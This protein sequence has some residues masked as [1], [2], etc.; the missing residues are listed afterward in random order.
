MQD[1]RERWGWPVP[2]AQSDPLDQVAFQVLGGPMG[3]RAPLAWLG[4]PVLWGLVVLW[5]LQAR[6]VWLARWV[7]V[8]LLPIRLLQT[9]WACV[10]Q[11]WSKR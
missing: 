11:L 3:R 1:H 6:L 7:L 9:L 2:P 8:A 10:S 5:D 4:K